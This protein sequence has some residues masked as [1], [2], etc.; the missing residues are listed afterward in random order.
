MLQ[1]YTIG[2]FTTNLCESWM[3]IRTKFDGGKQINRSQSG[4]WGGRCA[5]AGLRCNEGAG[6]GPSMWKTAVCTEPSDV[7]KLAAANAVKR[8]DNDRKRKA[9]A[10][11]K[12][13]RKKARY[14]TTSVDTA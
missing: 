4:S 11:A 3:H 12:L 14:S 6:W 1:I 7:F 13:Q 5:G 9:S 2:N 8:T 10:D